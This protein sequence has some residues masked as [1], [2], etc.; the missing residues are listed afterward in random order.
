MKP[1]ERQVPGAD[2]WPTTESRLARR[3]AGMLKPAMTKKFPEHPANPERVCWG[4]DKYCAADAMMCGNGSERTQHPAELFGEDWLKT[5]KDYA[6]ESS[7][8]KS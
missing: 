1:I 4:C 6:P 2:F 7:A 3:L 5:G 8:P